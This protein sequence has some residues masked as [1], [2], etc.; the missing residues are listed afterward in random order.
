MLADLRHTMPHVFDQGR[1]P[2]CLVAAVSDANQCNRG[3]PKKFSVEYLFY[4]CSE[5]DA[6][7]VTG[8]VSVSTIYDCLMMN[9]QPL[10]SHWPYITQQPPVS[11]WV[12]PSNSPGTVYGAHLKFGIFKFDAICDL[13][14]RGIPVVLL[15]SVDNSLYRVDNNGLLSGEVFGPFR[16]CHA[17]LCVGVGRT[18][19]NWLCVRNSWGACWADAGYAWMDEGYLESCMLSAA[20]L[21]QERKTEWHI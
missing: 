14:K 6:S 19:R 15:L 8:G 7:V 9:G 1:R 11:T 5:Q 2:T 13:V 21:P 10:D 17:M 4:K 12:E 18:D 16:G 20:Y 3:D